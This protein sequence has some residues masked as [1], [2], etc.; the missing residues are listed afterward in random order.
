ME[1]ER[2]LKMFSIMVLVIAIIGLTVALAAMSTTL[3]TNGVFALDQGNFIVV[4]QGAGTTDKY[5]EW[6]HKP[7]VNQHFIYTRNDD[8]GGYTDYLYTGERMDRI[9]GYNV[10]LSK[11]GDYQTL[12]FYIGNY[13][14]INVEITSLPK[15][16]PVCTSETGNK[17]DEKLICDNIKTRL[18]WINSLNSQVSD[19][20]K[21]TDIKVGDKILK[22]GAYKNDDS[23][24]DKHKDK[25]T[26]KVA[27]FKIE[28]DYNMD[29]L[30]TS[31]VTVSNLDFIPT[32]T[33][34]K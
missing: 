34:S 19:E 17:E 24:G 26:L 3:K 8:G 21:Y 18:A 22:A 11:P 1:K 23:W 9:D 4:I 20:E 14:D 15:I 5:Y 16:N 32:F 31:K 29:K 25:R 33:Q 7:I 30:P 10:S 12:I 2:R 13:S 27:A 28:L 6:Y